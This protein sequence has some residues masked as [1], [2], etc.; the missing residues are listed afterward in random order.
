MSPEPF[1]VSRVDEIHSAAKRSILDSLLEWKTQVVSRY[2]LSTRRFSFGQLANPRSRA[3]VSWASARIN[4]VSK[5][6]AS[7]AYLNR[8]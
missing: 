5:I 7:A 6:A 1:Q 2:R 4:F 8:G 3:T